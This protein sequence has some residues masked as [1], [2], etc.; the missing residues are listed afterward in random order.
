[1][2]ITVKCCLNIQA[3]VACKV[4]LLRKQGNEMKSKA[5]G[6]LQARVKQSTGY[7]LYVSLC[8]CRREVL[9][10]MQCWDSIVWQYADAQ[11]LVFVAGDAC[12]GRIPGRAN[13]SRQAAQHCAL[14]S[15][16]SS[17]VV[18]VK[19]GFLSI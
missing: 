19:V 15:T 1:M 9:C 5:A 11:R 12:P 16:A 17:Y 13:L 4:R 14:F 7:P 10:S 18:T 3:R 2:S 6:G 8:A